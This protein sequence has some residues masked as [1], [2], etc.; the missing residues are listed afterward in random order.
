MSHLDFVHIWGSNKYFCGGH[1]GLHDTTQSPRAPC[2]GIFGCSLTSDNS[3]D[4][5][6]DLIE[7]VHMHMQVLPPAPSLPAA[8]MVHV[9]VLPPARDA[10]QKL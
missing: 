1:H 3:S 10:L 8:L 2:T 5:L 4:M 7:P 6:S 9:Q